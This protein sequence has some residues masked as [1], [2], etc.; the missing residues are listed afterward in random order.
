MQRRSGRYAFYKRY[1]WNILLNSFRQCAGIFNA[2]ANNRPVS[3]NAKFG[4]SITN[5]GLIYALTYRNNVILNGIWCDNFL[6]GTSG[7]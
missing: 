1:M 6:R 4:S 7:E 3:T 5:E 2:V